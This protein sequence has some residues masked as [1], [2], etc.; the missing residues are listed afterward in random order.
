MFLG[1]R[2]YKCL[3]EILL[4]INFCIHPDG[5]LVDCMAILFLISRGTTLL[6]ST[7][8]ALFYIPTNSVQV[9]QFLH[10]LTNTVIL[11][12]CFVLF[13][14]VAITV[15]DVKWY[16]SVVLICISLMI[17]DIKDLFMGFLPTPISFVEKC[18]SKAFLK[19]D[20]LFFVAVVE[21]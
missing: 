6:L 20:C 14:I 21:L 5:G 7:V 2:I 1:T 13:V 10:I 9:F 19:S 4:T 12:F 18:L 15:T 8:V 3:F 16:L 11:R 17:S